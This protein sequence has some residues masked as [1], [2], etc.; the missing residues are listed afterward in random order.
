MAKR[1]YKCRACGASNDINKLRQRGGS[2]RGC[3]VSM[4]RKPSTQKPQ[5]TYRC[6]L[7]GFRNSRLGLKRRKGACGNINCLAKVVMTRKRLAKS[8][9]DKA[10]RA[11]K[12]AT[13]GVARAWLRVL[14]AAKARNA[15][16]LLVAAKAV[17]TY[18]RRARRAAILIGPNDIVRVGPGRTKRAIAF[19]TENL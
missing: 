9:V 12:L 6:K 14:S 13:A 4:Y 18:E 16:A 3:G 7:C 5:K 8:P 10:S 2:C 1:F 11:Y 19:S 15:K 17:A